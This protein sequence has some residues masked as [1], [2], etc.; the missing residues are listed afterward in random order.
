MARYS[1]YHSN[2]ILSRV[3]QNTK[4]GKIWLRDWVTI[5]SQHQIEKGKKPYYSDTNFLFTDNSYPS[6]HKKHNFGKWVAHWIY[7]D[8]KDSKEEA[9]KVKVNTSSNDIRDFA[10][11]GSAVELVK[12]SVSDIIN[13]FPAS[14]SI[15]VDNVTVPD[16]KGGFTPV[17]SYKYVDNPFNLDFIHTLSDKEKE[18]NNP[19]R[20]LAESYENYLIDGNPITKYEI[21]TRKFVYTSVGGNDYKTTTKYVSDSFTFNKDYT[22]EIG[23]TIV[24]KSLKHGNVE[25]LNNKVEITELSY[26]K[27]N[28]TD[29]I[30]VKTYNRNTGEVVIDSDTKT[31]PDISEVEHS[32]AVK[33]TVSGYGFRRILNELQYNGTDISVTRNTNWSQD[34]GEITLNPN[35]YYYVGDKWIEPIPV[36][37]TVHV[38]YHTRINPDPLHPEK[39]LRYLKIEGYD[40]EFNILPDSKADINEIVEDY[41]FYGYTQPDTER[42]TADT[43]T[44]RTA[45]NTN[46]STKIGSDK[47]TF[48]GNYKFIVWN[49]TEGTYTGGIKELRVNNKEVYYNQGSNTIAFENDTTGSGIY[50]GFEG[51]TNNNFTVSFLK[52]H[53]NTD[54]DYSFTVHP[55]LLLDI[56]DYGKYYFEVNGQ[57]YGF[58]TTCYKTSDSPYTVNSDLVVSWHGNSLKLIQNGSALVTSTITDETANVLLYKEN[59]TYPVYTFIQCTKD[60]VPQGCYPLDCKPSNWMPKLSIPVSWDVYVKDCSDCTDGECYVPVLMS[61]EIQPEGKNENM[62]LYEVT[63][64]DTYK[65]YGYIKDGEEVILTDNENAVITPKREM[66]DEFFSN[67]DGFEKQLLT[68][69][70]KPVYSNSFLTP[71]EGELTYKYVYRDYTWPS[72][73]VIYN[74]EEQNATEGITYHLIDIGSEVYAE[75]LSKLLDMAGV[76]DELWCDNLYKNM[77]HESIKNFDW[78]YT[79]EYNEGD[80]EDNIEGGNRMQKLIRV[81][82]RF[83]DDIKRN[84]DGIKFSANNT[85]DGNNNEPDAEISDRLETSGWDITSVI[86]DINDNNQGYINKETRILITEEEWSKLDTGEQ[87]NYEPA[88]YDET[89]LVFLTETEYND[90]EEGKERFMKYY[91]ALDLTGVTIDKNFIEGYNLQGEKNKLEWFG[92]LSS[93]NLTC[94]KSEIDFM[95]KLLLCSDRIFNTKGTRQSIEMVM[96]MFG[97]TDEKL[98]EEDEPDYEIEEGYYTTKPISYDDNYE[99]IA[100]INSSKNYPRQYDDAYSGIPLN[101]IFIWVKKDDDED[102]KELKRYII[103]YY[104]QKRKYDGDF[105]FES[106]G[107]WGKMNNVIETED[108]GTKVIEGEYMET[109]SYLHVVS[110]FGDLLSLNPNSL[111]EGDIYYVA[112]IS[113]YSGYVAVLPDNVSHFFHL[114]EEVTDGDEI[115]SESG[116]YNPQLPESWENVDI[117]DKEGT[118]SKKARYLNSLISTNTGNNPHVGYGLYDGGNEYRQ[119][120]E[121]PFKYSLDEYLLPNDMA[122]EAE[123]IGFELKEEFTRKYNGKVMNLIDT[124]NTADNSSAEDNNEDEPLKY[125][126]NRKYLKIINKKGKD[127]EMFKKYFIDVILKFIMQIIPSSSI[128]ILENFKSSGKIVE[129]GD[130]HITYNY[131]DKIKWDGSNSIKPVFDY[132]VDVTY[133]D[134]STGTIRPE[135]ATINFTT[136]LGQIDNKGVITVSEKNENEEDKDGTATVVVAYKDKTE[137]VDAVFSQSGKKIDSYSDMKITYK[138]KET[139]YN[140]FPPGEVSGQPFIEIEQTFYYTDGTVETVICNTYGEITDYYD[141]VE[142]EVIRGADNVDVEDTGFINIHANHNKEIRLAGIVKVTIKKGEEEYSSTAEIWQNGLLVEYGEVTIET[143]EYDTIPSSGG[144]VTPKLSWKQDIIYK[145]KE[146]SPAYTETVT[147]TNDPSATVTYSGDFVTSGKSGVVV[148]NTPNTSEEETEVGTVTVTIISNGKQNSKPTTLKQEKKDIA[149][150]GNLEITEFT[151]PQI[152]VK[153]SEEAVKPTI[154]VVEYEIYTDG[155]RVKKEYNSIEE[156]RA[157]EGANV[158]F[159]DTEGIVEQTDG[160]VKKETPNLTPDTVIVDSV[161]VKVTLHDNVITANYLVTQGSRV[162]ESYGNVELLTGIDKIY[163]IASSAS[164]SSTSPHFE[165]RQPIVY[166]DSSTEYEYNNPKALISYTAEGTLIGNSEVDIITGK[167]TVNEANTN[168]GEGSREIGRIKINMS[169]NGKGW[170]SDKIVT[171]KQKNNAISGYTD[172]YDIV[173]T[174]N[175]IPSS[176]GSVTPVLSYK[177]D[178]IY[179]N[180]TSEQKEYTGSQ[181]IEHSRF[182]S[183]NNLVNTTTG[184]ITKGTV[185]ESSV[186]E[187]VDTVSVLIDLNGKNGRQDT[188]VYQSPNE[189][190]YGEIVIDEFSYQKFA[191]YA[192]SSLTPTV[193]YRQKVTYSDGTERWLTPE[194]MVSVTVTFQGISVTEAKLDRY[195]GEAT[196][197]KANTLTT[198]RIIFDYIDLNIVNKGQSATRKAYDI[199]QLGKI[200]TYY[201]DIVIDK[202]KFDGRIPSKGNTAATPLY[203]ILEYSQDVTYSDGSTENLTSAVSGGSMVYDNIHSKVQFASDPDGILDGDFG[204]V[205]KTTPNTYDSDLLVG[206]I[207]VMIKCTEPGAVN[208]PIATDSEPV[209]QLAREI[210][211]YEPIRITKFRYD[212]IPSQGGSVWPALEYEMDIKYDN[213]TTVTWKSTDVDFA[214]KSF[215]DIPEPGMSVQINS[216]TGVITKNTPSDSRVPILVAT[217]KVS[218]SYTD[219]TYSSS[220]E[221]RTSVRQIDKI[222]IGYGEVIITD[223]AYSPAKV[224]GNGGTVN[225]TTLS[226]KQD[227]YYDDGTSETLINEVT[228]DKNI[229]YTFDK[230]SSIE[231]VI[232][233]DSISGELSKATINTTGRLLDL[234]NVTVELTLHEKVGTKTLLIQQEVGEKR[235]VGYSDVRISKFTYPTLLIDGG[236]NMPPTYLEYSQDIIY[237]FGPNETRTNKEHNGA[238]EQ[239][240]IPASEI[241]KIFSANGNDI[242]ISTDGKITKTTRNT[243]T[244][245]IVGDANVN[246]T[247]NMKSFDKSTNIYQFTYNGQITPP[248]PDTPVNP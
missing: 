127:N 172:I 62:A 222:I 146:E 97:L 163:E 205:V 53:T 25:L 126:L 49:S 220:G 176:G 137:S 93:E 11:Y 225:P 160:G 69:D 171:V 36:L 161:N 111:N 196:V 212:D 81:Y 23:Y 223:F 46:G 206:N 168:V 28:V 191:P 4:L 237:N 245:M 179:K 166:T 195:T 188:S 234:G 99:N 59:V 221:K 238:M 94:T 192:N 91:P 219:G 142:Y 147:I 6:Y 247:I 141:S 57:R 164:G 189:V 228:S 235:I 119:Y 134:G 58:T 184:V 34:L 121:K 105:V 76:F 194:E 8:V 75:Y 226:Y 133:E 70:S 88:Y 217:V 232:N 83:F 214:T 144:T 177:Q 246:I 37:K 186:P 15:S 156:I 175:Y 26:V 107:G 227:V 216:L 174:Y 143:F 96:G 159:T 65:F 155:S 152:S 135:D 20:F 79:R 52:E 74:T 89:N 120:M 43:I 229:L 124:Y 86:P 104:T 211:G 19:D 85:Y 64:N 116:I 197:V 129:Y 248:D 48:T 60:G 73:E 208:V 213:G 63:V 167:V 112:D 139:G 2:Y 149:G 148:K 185:N 47:Y 118:V 101:D 103:P 138:Y 30:T 231:D 10:Y 68:L 236:S 87:A 130:I 55:C 9:N 114:K 54:F 16:G 108:E 180:G 200:I 209:Y 199:K 150:Y 100:E 77:T 115:I 98:S 21:L 183:V 80:E 113:T 72:K 14:I 154:K 67:L 201:G 42:E 145:D 132:Y 35:F 165:Y 90:L 56:T 38:T 78:T 158:E 29:D 242:T 182:Y 131:T 240:E 243:S 125:Y 190:T 50:L 140:I 181:A 13:R 170:D 3:H 102:E 207:T 61:K 187:I 193:K 204:N 198:E 66:V 71:I 162:I 32:V 230:N 128:L 33:N 82:G 123:N 95:K 84:I 40:E 22:E 41:T 210:T 5:G 51:I 203:A 178:I 39:P 109:M 241:T 215:M 110:S 202:F 239:E 27:D 17:D 117:N 31:L 122:E 173:L 24:P 18:T 151:Y 7:D 92:S 45:I 106:K 244:N 157:V 44:I 153:G 233:F 224:S 218:L 136:T 1:K 169:C 12:S